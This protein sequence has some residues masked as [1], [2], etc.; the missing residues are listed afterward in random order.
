MTVLLQSLQKVQYMR[1]APIHYDI[2]LDLPTE[3]AF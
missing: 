2:L 3:S 1:D